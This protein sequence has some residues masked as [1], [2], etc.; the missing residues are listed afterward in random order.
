MKKTFVAIAILTCLLACNT[1]KEKEAQLTEK[2]AAATTEKRPYEFADER[3]V[4]L[5]KK[6]FAALSAKD[7]DTWASIFAEKAYYEWNN[8]DTL[9]GKTA[10]SEYWKKRMTETI[11][12]LEFKNEIWLPVTVNKPAFE[13]QATG[14][15]V[16]NWNQVTAKYKTGKVMKQ[17][18]HTALHFDANDKVD[19]LIQYLDRVPIMKAMTK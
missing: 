19:Y 11:E 13:G 1:N 4:D 14:T 5:A 12:T 17:Y 10:I 16:L 3:Y 7:V 18:I 8:G 6:A 9:V 15:Y 2:T